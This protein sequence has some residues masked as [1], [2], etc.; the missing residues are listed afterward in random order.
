MRLPGE[1]ESELPTK[2]IGELSANAVPSI[3]KRVLVIVKFEMFM[4]LMFFTV[5][6]KT[7][8]SPDPTELSLSVTTS[9]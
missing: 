4:L 9:E 6:V 1:E 2:V 5:V 7:I 3:P 8:T